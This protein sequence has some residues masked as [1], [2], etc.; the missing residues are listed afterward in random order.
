VRFKL[1]EDTP[2]RLAALLR[3][4]GHDADTVQDEGLTGASDATVARAAAQ[5]GRVLVSLDLG[6]SDIRAYPPGS[7]PG[8]IV[9]RPRGGHGAIAVA[10]V[11]TALLD[12]PQFGADLIGCITIVDP[13]RIR[14]RR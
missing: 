13:Q 6:F 5:D 7:H 11:F 3:E 9:I 2:L 4:R 12:S 14:I 8:I 1:D 10:R